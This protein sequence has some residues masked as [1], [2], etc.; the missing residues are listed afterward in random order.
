VLTWDQSSDLDVRIGGKVDIRHQADPAGGLGESAVSIAEASG[1]AALAQVPFKRGT[2]YIRFIDQAGNAS[3]FT[4]FS[5]DTRRPVPFAQLISAGVFS[6]NNS[7]EDQV[8]IQ[9]DPTFPSTNV[10]NTLSEDTVNQW[11][12]LPAA[13]TWDDITNI[14]E[15][16]DIDA[17]GGDGTVA[18]EGV[19]FFSTGI[20][21]NAVTRMMVETVIETEIVD[22]SNSWDAIADIDEVADI[23]AIGA[24]TAQPGQADAWI[25]A[26]TTRDDPAGS[27]TFGP[28]QRVDSGIFNHRAIEFR[29]QARSFADTVNIRI[30]QARVLVRELPVDF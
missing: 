8:T 3:G 21:L 26:R 28:W 11:L 1:D 27:P 17:I 18:P 29:I 25:E 20:A 4:E 30:K 16:A 23:D 15:V 12:Q 22:E 13:Q 5:L 6:A 10:G 14:D 2:Y 9:E 19:Y 7:T 24:G